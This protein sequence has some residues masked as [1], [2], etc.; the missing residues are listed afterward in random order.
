MGGVGGVWRE[1]AAILNRII[2][3]DL[4]EKENVLVKT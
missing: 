4:T 3:G 2:N 1:G